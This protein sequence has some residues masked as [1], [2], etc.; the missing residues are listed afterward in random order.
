MSQLS[1]QDIQ[2]L[3]RLAR[4]NLTQEEQERFAPQLSAVVE[5]IEQLKEVDTSAITQVK[6]VTGMHNVL[7]DDVVR[8]S[9]DQIAVSREALL[10]GAPA[11]KNT[12]F[13]VRAVLGEEVT[14]A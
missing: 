2:H 1:S 13:L 5:Y 8:S 12:L 9:D 14:G 6:G 10:A 7:A 3:G 4:L 11:A